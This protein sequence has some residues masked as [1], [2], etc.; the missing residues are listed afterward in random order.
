MHVSWTFLDKRAAAVNAIRA[1]KD[2]EFIIETTPE[3]I[4]EQK[5]L[6]VS[7]KSAQLTGTPG[8]NDPRRGEQRI[9]AIIDEIDIS[10]ERYRQALEYVEWFEPAWKELTDTERLILTEFYMSATLRSG[11]TKKLEQVLNY[12]HSQV[13]RLR[14]KALARFSQ[15][16]Y[17]L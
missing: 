6:M 12:G 16:L 2:M 11:A 7:P 4:K 1:Y 13:D 9:A 8:M 10:R 14:S 15:L 17:G 3:N 5:I